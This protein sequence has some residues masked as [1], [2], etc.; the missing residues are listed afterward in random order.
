MPLK[1]FGFIYYLENSTVFLPVLRE[2][3]Y[4]SAILVSFFTEQFYRMKSV[5]LSYYYMKE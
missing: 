2:K 3:I 4:I 5:G 1:Y